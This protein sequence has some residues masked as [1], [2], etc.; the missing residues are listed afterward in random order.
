MLEIVEDRSPIEVW[1]AMA[2]HFLDTETRQDI[3]LTA[4]RCVEAALS[5]MEA[6]HVWQHE[7]SPAV[8]FNLWVVAGEWAYWDRDWL[9][10]RIERHRRSWR[11]RTRFVKWLGDCMRIDPARCVCTSI[12]RTMDFLAAVPDAGDREQACRRLAFLAQH[13][14]DFCP[15]DL[16][17]V[18]PSEAEKIRSLYP[19][20]FVYTMEPVL[21]AAE[22]RLADARVRA[23]FE[24]AEP[25]P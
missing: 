20:P 19:E 10:E 14:F 16:A 9:V 7:V 5:P 12:E 23:A 21:S 1:V 4:M 18:D 6:R 11:Q 3:P 2:N 25:C 13:Y 22:A 15:A 17:T 8:G 24:K